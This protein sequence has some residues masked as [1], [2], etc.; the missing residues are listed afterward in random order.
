[1]NQAI[2]SNDRAP[3]LECR[4]ILDGVRNEDEL[5]RMITPKFIKDSG[6]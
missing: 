3:V 5:V 4:A 1:V 6:S 2:A